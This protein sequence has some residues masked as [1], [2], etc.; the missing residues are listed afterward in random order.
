MHI[1]SSHPS[2]GPVDGDKSWHLRTGPEICVLRYLDRGGHYQD[3]AIVSRGDI[4]ALILGKH[5]FIL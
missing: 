3:P 2:M 5:E 4:Q 1:P